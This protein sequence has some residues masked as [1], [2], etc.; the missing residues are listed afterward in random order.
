MDTSTTLF[1]TLTHADMHVLYIKETFIGNVVFV[2]GYRLVSNGLSSKNLV[3][4]NSRTH[5]TKI[6][7]VNVEQ[8][9]T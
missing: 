7:K 1:L 3:I 6:N 4:L 8:K 9:L 5:F 2:Y